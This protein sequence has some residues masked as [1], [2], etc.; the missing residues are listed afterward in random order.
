[1][2]KHRR[3]FIVPD[4]EPFVSRPNPKFSRLSHPTAK[5]RRTP[6]FFE[7]WLPVARANFTFCRQL[8][9]NHEAPPRTGTPA[10]A[11]TSRERPSVGISSW[12]ARMPT[13]R[14]S[15]RSV[16]ASLP[17]RAGRDAAH[18]ADESAP[19]FPPLDA[20]A[21]PSLTPLTVSPLSLPSQARGRRPTRGRSRSGTDGARPVVSRAR[22]RTAPPAHFS[23]FSRRL[24]SRT[25][26]GS[27]TAS[28]RPLILTPPPT[29]P[30]SFPA[31]RDREHG[32][33]QVRL[34]PPRAAPRLPGRA[35]P[36]R[37]KCVHPPLFPVHPVL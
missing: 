17:S 4:R 25:P 6:T 2:P 24:A 13:T 3:Y 27:P 8:L 37:V 18:A 7:D 5:R 32:M 31:G 12:R 26:P 36:P 19:S 21:P 22:L 23:S 14:L 29:F 28:P 9:D 1:M 34:R 15:W 20:S 11:A 33:R 16:G 30:P 10:S 35:L